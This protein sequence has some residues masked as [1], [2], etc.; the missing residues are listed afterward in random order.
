[1]EK[2]VKG[3]NIE[4]KELPPDN[5]ALL[6]RISKVNNL[7]PNITINFSRMREITDPLVFCYFSFVAAKTT[8]QAS[9]CLLRQQLN[10]GSSIKWNE[11][12]PSLMAV[13]VLSTHQA[14]VGKLYSL[15]MTS[16]HTA[17]L[18]Q[19]EQYP[20]HSVTYHR[21]YGFNRG[22]QLS[23]HTSQGKTLAVEEIASEGHA[24]LTT[25]T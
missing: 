6:K 4:L 11:L 13:T 23:L 24:N 2:I 18:S 14:E 1:M 10:D 20:V 16:D 7:G 17:H 3:E 12:N 22:D 21:H 19:Q 5:V 8:D 25:F 9:S 15:C